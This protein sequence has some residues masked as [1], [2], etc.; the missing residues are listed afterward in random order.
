M[1]IKLGTPG[2]E[3][4]FYFASVTTRRIK[5]YSE[6]TGLDGSKKIQQAPVIKKRFEITFVKI[7]DETHENI[8]N[9]NTEYAKGT[10]LNL[11]Y[12]ENTYSVVFLGEL[13]SSTSVYGTDIILQ[14]V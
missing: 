7:F 13:A 9:L 1:E 14:E 8:T 4:I 12:N 10:V 3:V 6:H 2:S 11:I 5:I